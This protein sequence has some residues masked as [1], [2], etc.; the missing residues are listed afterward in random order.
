MTNETWVDGFGLVSIMACFAWTRRA[1][2]WT[3][4]D[5]GWRMNQECISEE[6]SSKGEM[7]MET[8][9]NEYGMFSILVCL[10]E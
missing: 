1:G 8:M 9:Y 3:S 4:F 2:Q 10:Y 7:T 6:I 5:Q